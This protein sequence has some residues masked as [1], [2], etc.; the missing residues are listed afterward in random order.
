MDES[1]Q[2]GQSR[3]IYVGVHSGIAFRL[4]VS[5]VERAVAILAFVW[6]SST[7][8]RIGICSL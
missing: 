8:K 6:S 5:E 1:T 7:V 2:H 3:L 4:V